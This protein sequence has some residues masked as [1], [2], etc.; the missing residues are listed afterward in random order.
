MDM[1]ACA[2]HAPN[3]SSIHNYRASNKEKTK[4]LNYTNIYYFLVWFASLSLL[5]IDFNNQEKA[6]FISLPC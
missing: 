5:F 1:N 3:I 6:P 4:K 2:L